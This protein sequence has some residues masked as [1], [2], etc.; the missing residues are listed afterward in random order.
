MKQVEFEV[1]PSSQDYPVCYELADGYCYQLLN[2]KMNYSDRT[3][4]VQRVRAFDQK[5]IRITNDSILMT[6]ENMGQLLKEIIR[7]YEHR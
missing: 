2:N 4:E 3:F 6:I 1:C 5:P 7:Y